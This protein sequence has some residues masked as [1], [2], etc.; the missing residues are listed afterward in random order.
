MPPITEMMSLVA[1]S[2]LPVTIACTRAGPPP[3]SFGPGSSLRPYL[4]NSPI[5]SAMLLKDSDG[6]GVGSSSVALIAIGVPAVC[7]WLTAG[8]AAMA[9]AV[10]A[11]TRKAAVRRS[12]AV[13]L[14]IFH[15]PKADCCWGPKPGSPVRS[16]RP[17][18]DGPI[19]YFTNVSYT[20]GGPPCSMRQVRP[21]CKLCGPKG[22]Q[23]P[24]QL[25]RACARTG[26]A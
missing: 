24:V 1:T 2:E 21:C 5:A 6:S 11:N 19:L 17:I 8:A 26:A 18:R 7:A 4:P 16:R 15:L 9:A 23:Q 3:P 13:T 20:S 25:L 10:P 22:A 14:D 12:G